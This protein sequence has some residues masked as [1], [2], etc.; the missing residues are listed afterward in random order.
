M[1]STIETTI[2]VG[3]RIVT[4][5]G[6]IGTL[7][8]YDDNGLPYVVVRRRGE[9]AWRLVRLTA[10][11]EMSVDEN[12]SEPGPTLNEIGALYIAKQQAIEEAQARRI[13]EA[14]ALRTEFD[15]YKEKV[16][17]VALRKKADE[18]WCDSGFNEAMRELDLPGVNLRWRVP[19]VV[20]ATQ[21]VYLTVEAADEDDAVAEAE[22][23][24]DSDSVWNL[25]QSY[26]WE[27]DTYEV[28]SR[29]DVE[30]DDE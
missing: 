9:T 16:R 17:E 10:V 27:Y 5:A 14:D 2:P 8:G 19:V 12:P 30:E 13:G 29:Y 26:E 23:E 1:T 20:T 25:I 24:A 15:A 18:N 3:S 7:L 22:N 11:T 4:A 21:T 28:G 6:N